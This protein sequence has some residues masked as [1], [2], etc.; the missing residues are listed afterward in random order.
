MHHRQKVDAPSGTAI[1]L[2]R[3]VAKG[4]GVVLEDVKESGR[5]GVPRAVFHDGCAGHGPR[6]LSQLFTNGRRDF[7][8]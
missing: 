3:A 7:L 2:G 4:R 8:I 6:T 5:D 1:G